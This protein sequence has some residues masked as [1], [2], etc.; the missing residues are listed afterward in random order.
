MADVILLIAASLSPARVR[1]L[2]L[3]QNGWAWRVLL[4]IHGEQ[5]LE[6]ICDEVDMVGINNRDLRTFR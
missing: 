3:L 5:E 6:H 1:N 2:G 4:E